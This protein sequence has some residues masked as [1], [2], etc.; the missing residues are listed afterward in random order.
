MF[1][2]VERKVR[3]IL[4]FFL[5]ILFLGLTAAFAALNDGIINMNYFIGESEIRLTYL[6][7]A[8]IIFGSLMSLI[9]L[10]GSYLKM[11]FELRKLRNS[12][13]VQNEELS[14][15]RALPVKEP[16]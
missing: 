15:L 4:Q 7:L 11:R 5:M 9:M 6:L 3:A 1:F 13:A 12:V 16:Y 14:N 8:C 10:S 2:F